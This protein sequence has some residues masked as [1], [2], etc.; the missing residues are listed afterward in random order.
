LAAAG[1]VSSFLY[2]LACSRAPLPLLAPLDYLLLIWAAL[3][4]FALWG[5]RPNPGV[6]LGGGPI[7]AATILCEMT[8]DP[9]R[10][11]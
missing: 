3:W 8:N 10:S 6:W 1:G 2:V 11:R 7:V 5:E 9:A 4:G